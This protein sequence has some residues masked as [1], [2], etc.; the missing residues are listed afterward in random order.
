MNSCENLTLFSFSM[1]HVQMPGLV[2]SLAHPLRLNVE[3]LVRSEVYS[4][5]LGI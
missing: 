1:N 5:E 3:L 4:N 2:C